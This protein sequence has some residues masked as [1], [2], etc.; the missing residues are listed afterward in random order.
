MEARLLQLSMDF[1][2]ATHIR[3]AAT[4]HRTIRE[5]ISVNNEVIVEFCFRVTKY[6]ILEAKCKPQFRCT[7]VCRLWDSFTE[8]WVCVVHTCNGLCLIILC[9]Q[10]LSNAY[11]VSRILYL[12]LTFEGNSESNKQLYIYFIGF[13]YVKRF[14][15]ALNIHPG[16]RALLRLLVCIV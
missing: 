16:C 11:L 2:K 13:K 12:I 14:L 7:H 3:I 1:H 5:N 10:C 15:H 9:W 4:T 8:C 6:A